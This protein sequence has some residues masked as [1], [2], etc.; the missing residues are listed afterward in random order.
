MRNAIDITIIAVYLIGTV[1][2]GCSFF[3]KKKRRGSGADAQQR[4]PPAPFTIRANN[5]STANKR[6][7]SV[8]LNGKL[9]TRP[10]IRHAD[11]LAGGTLVFEMGE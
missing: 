2:F 10:V 6:V 5:L 9:L 7:K 8:T 4:V 1:I 3:W 11:I